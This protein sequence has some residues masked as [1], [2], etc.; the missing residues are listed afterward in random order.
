MVI[1][2][3]LYNLL[4]NDFLGRFQ[5]IILNGQTSWWRPVVAG[6]LQASILVPLL[7]LLYIND[8]PN[9][10]KSSAKMFADDTSLLTIVKDSNESAN[11]FNNNQLLII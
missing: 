6:V 10:S 9:K 5:R 2:G 11:I 7:F 4:G 1:S 3:Q 8:L